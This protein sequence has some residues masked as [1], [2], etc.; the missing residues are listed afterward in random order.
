MRTKGTLTGSANPE[1]LLVNLFGEAFAGDA[2]H[3]P[4]DHGFVMLGQAFVVAGAAAVS[5]DPGQGAFDDSAS[6]YDDES[7]GVLG[8]LTICTVRWSCS[9]AQ[10]TSLP[11]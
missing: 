5:G 10:V 2:D 7:G 11:A 3:A 6:G 4:V 1:S 9:D 8:R